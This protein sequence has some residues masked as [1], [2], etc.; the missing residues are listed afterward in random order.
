MAK[1]RRKSAL[2]RQGAQMTTFGGDKAKANLK[3]LFPQ[4]QIIPTRNG[5]IKIEYKPNFAT[6]F[7][8]NLNKSQAFLDNKVIIELQRYVSKKYGVQEMSIRYAS[9][10]RKWES[11]Y[12]STLCRISSLLKTY[13]KTCRAS[14]NSTLGTYGR[15]QKS[16]Y[17]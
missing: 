14:W 11:T 1:K 8:A 15:R 3:V 12:C 7:N 9:Y 17:F 2:I 13:T 4:A 6:K 16:I 10:P 5:N